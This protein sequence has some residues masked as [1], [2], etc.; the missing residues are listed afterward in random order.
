MTLCNYNRVLLSKI[1]RFLGLTVF[2]CN[3]L[4][5]S[6]ALSA[7]ATTQNPRGWL[8]YNKKVY[9]PQKLGEEPRP[10]VSSICLSLYR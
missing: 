9:P 7:I 2:E 8:K 10:A 3:K 4:H 1:D 6:S 5:T